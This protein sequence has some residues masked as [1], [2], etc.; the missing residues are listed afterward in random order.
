MIVWRRLKP[1]LEELVKGEQRDQTDGVSSLRLPVQIVVVTPDYS[2]TL[3]PD[4]GGP[5]KC[6]RTYHCH[7][8][9]INLEQPTV[10]QV[11]REVRE[12][13]DATCGTRFTPE[14]DFV[15]KKGRFTKRAKQ[16]AIA[17]VTEDGMPLGRVPQR[18]WRD[19]HV[20]VTKSTVHKWVHE[21]AEA[22][23]GAAEYTQWVTA[24]F[25]GVVGIDEVHLRDENGKKQY[26]VVA[27]DPINDRT[28]LFDLIDSRDSDALKGFLEQLQAMGVD[29]LVVVTDMWKAYHSAIL[30]VFPEAEHQL[31]VFHVIQAMM[32]HTNKARLA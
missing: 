29:P 26:L 32:K 18:M 31:C 21:E 8:Q 25:S 22:D 27:V 23:L 12:C 16:K 15:A 4:C 19:F 14:L 28:I 5:T 7:P 24:R 13:C 9:D 11:Y 20:H 6:K 3:C 10:L 1:A 17:S 30:D 2:Q